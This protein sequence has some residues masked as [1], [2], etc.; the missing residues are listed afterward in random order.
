MKQQLHRVA[1][2]G[3]RFTIETDMFGQLFGSEVVRPTPEEI[4]V[5]HGIYVQ[6]VNARRGTEEQAAELRR[7][8]LRII[9][10]ESVE[11]I[12]LAGTELALLIDEDRADYP[13]VDCARLHIEEITRQATK[14]RRVGV[15]PLSAAF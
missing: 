15:D 3:T 11:A 5:I 4:D 9:T 14:P 12:V 1:L 7:I 8:A 10:R 13:I 6:I 2:F